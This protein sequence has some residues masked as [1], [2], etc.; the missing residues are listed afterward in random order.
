MDLDLNLNLESPC[1]LQVDL[2]SRPK[3][4]GCVRTRARADEAPEKV[5]YFL[6]SPLSLP[7]P[8]PSFV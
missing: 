5:S 3:I 7:L 2:P 4:K 8:S 1:Q 6:F